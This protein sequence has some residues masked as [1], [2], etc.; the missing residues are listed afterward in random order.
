MMI[1]FINTYFKNRKNKKTTVVINAEDMI[2]NRDHFP[3]TTNAIS[4]SEKIA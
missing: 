2:M 1:T 4:G 3:G